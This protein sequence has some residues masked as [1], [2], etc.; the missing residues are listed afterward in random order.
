MTIPALNLP[1]H[2][3]RELTQSLLPLLW[4]LHELLITLAHKDGTTASAAAAYEACITSELDK[5]QPGC[6]T[7]AIEMLAVNTGDD[8]GAGL[9]ISAADGRRVRSLVGYFERQRPDMVREA[10]RIY[11]RRWAYG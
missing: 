3:Q 7:A 8:D 10:K 1:P 2:Y 6:L 11:G 4:E 5:D 9:G